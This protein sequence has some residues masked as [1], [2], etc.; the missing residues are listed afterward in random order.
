[1]SCLTG[2]GES[3]SMLHDGGSQVLEKYHRRCE[4]KERNLKM[5]ALALAAA[6]ALGLILVITAI[7]NRGAGSLHPAQNK[8][9]QQWEKFEDGQESEEVITNPE[10]FTIQESGT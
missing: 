5:A 1:M 6:I 9:A 4:M 8:A 10:G 7:V 2:T 3:G